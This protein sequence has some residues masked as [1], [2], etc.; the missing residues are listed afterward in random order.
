[1]K[2]LSEADLRRLAGLPEK[3]I[4]ENNISDEAV[5]DI[6]YQLKDL[7][8]NDEYLEM[9]FMV[10]NGL[11]ITSHPLLQRYWMGRRRMVAEY[12]ERMLQDFVEDPSDMESGQLY[13]IYEFA[14]RIYQGVDKVFSNNRITPQI[15]QFLEANKTAVIRKILLKI[16]DQNGINDSIHAVLQLL[17]SI[18]INWPELGKITKG[19]Y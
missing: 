5:E 15:K 9:E 3:P 14:N 17:K 6:L 18:G 13:D 10:D 4:N 8:E 12:L 1:M 19:P 2:P 7:A 11:D 16:K